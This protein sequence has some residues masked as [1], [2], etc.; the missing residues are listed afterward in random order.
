MMTELAC[1]KCVYWVRREDNPKYGTCHLSP[2]VEVEK[3]SYISDGVIH[4]Q[5]RAIF[6]VTAENEFCGNIST[7]TELRRINIQSTISDEHIHDH[8][9]TAFGEIHEGETVGG[10]QSDHFVPKGLSAAEE[11]ASEKLLRSVLGTEQDK[12]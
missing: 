9:C 6:P 5:G 8:S 10:P 11:K 1:R 7:P 4:Y 3:E 2:P 12:Q